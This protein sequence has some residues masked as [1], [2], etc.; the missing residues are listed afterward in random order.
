MSYW[1]YITGVVEVSPCGETQ[2]QKRYVLDTVLAHLPVVSGSER[3]MKVH[4]V[5]QYGHT[6][7]SSCDE[8]GDSLWYRRCADNDGWMKTQDLYTLVLEASLR[9]RTFEETK[10]EL[11]RW[12]NR[13]AKRVWVRDILVRLTGEDRTLVIGDPEPYDQ[14]YEPFSYMEESNG[15][16][17]WVEYLLWDP[18]KDSRY[19]LKLMYK[20]YSDPENDVEYM[21]RL[22]WERE[23]R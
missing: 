15:V 2:P 13:L 1:T 16:P 23:E 5:Q 8:F 11:C 10:R 4:V 21:R 3:D 17:N 19:P 12:L 14:M 20:Y 6:R 7:A 18:A 22:V 9:D